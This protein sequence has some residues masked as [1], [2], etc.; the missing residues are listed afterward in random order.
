[1]SL[2]AELRAL[3]GANAVHDA[4]NID[5]RH[6]HDWMV[7]AEPGVTPLAVVYPR[8]TEEVSAV[9]RTCHA[10]GQAVVPQGGL[11]GLV[12]GAVPVRD[13]V[14]LSTE[15]MRS[16]E[17][18]DCANATMTVQAGVT[19]QEAQEAADA[20]GLLYPLDIGGG[21]P[22]PPRGRAF[23]HPRGEAGGGETDWGAPPPPPPRGG[24]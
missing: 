18:V 16:I 4:K 11:T 23:C 15:R 21:G 9:L 13:C 8:S 19:L 22:G 24:P 1:M 7:A 3:L 20:A 2:V 5:P 12:G 14:V 10:H 6:L 17:E